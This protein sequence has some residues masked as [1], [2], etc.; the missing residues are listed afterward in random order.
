MLVNSE[1]EVGQKGRKVG[2]IWLLLSVLFIVIS[3]IEVTA[4]KENKATGIERGFW[5]ASLIFWCIMGVTL[6]ITKIR[7]K[8]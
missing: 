8:N 5:I 7:K 4:F 3:V 2:W 6:I 1:M